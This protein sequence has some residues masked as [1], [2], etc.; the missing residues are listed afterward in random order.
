MRT[1]KLLIELLMLLTGRGKQF[2]LQLYK[3]YGKWC[4][5]TK[6]RAEYTHHKSKWC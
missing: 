4:A 3:E 1:Q 2:Y 6:L 5:K